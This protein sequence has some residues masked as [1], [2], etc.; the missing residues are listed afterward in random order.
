ME[1]IVYFILLAFAA[2]VLGTVGGFGSSL[3][4]VP[5]AGYFF[6]FH[7]VLGITALFHVMSNLTKIAFFRDGIDK[8]LLLWLGLPAVIFVIVGAWLSAYLDAKILEVILACFLIIISLALMIFKNLVVKPTRASSITGGTISGLAAG[9][10]GTG[11]A[12]RGITLAAFN[13]ETG[14]FIATSAMIDL[15]P[16]AA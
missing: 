5:I 12:I 3:F 10:L 11:G 4:F 15:T 6:D 1:A 7:S 13:L 16:A 14:V 2:E 8:K 9:L